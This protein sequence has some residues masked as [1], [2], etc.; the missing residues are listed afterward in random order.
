MVPRARL[1][2]EVKRQGFGSAFYELAYGCIH[3]RS[4]QAASHDEDDGPFARKTEMFG[5]NGR[6][7][8]V[9]LNRIQDLRSQRIA[10]FDDAFLGE[11][12]LQSRKARANQA[13]AFGEQAV[14][15]AGERV[16]FLYGCRDAHAGGLVEHRSA[17]KSADANNQLRSE[18]SQDAAGVPQRADELQR[19]DPIPQAAPIPVY[20]CDPKAFDRIPGGG[21]FFHFHAPF[22]PDK[23][24]VAMGMFALDLICDGEGRVDVAAGAAAGDDDPVQWALRISHGLRVVARCGSWRGGLSAW[25]SSNGPTVPGPLRSAKQRGSS[26]WRGT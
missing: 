7:E 15:D 4:A 19:E 8:C 24:D 5:C 12:P 20:S 26:R 14:G 23:E 11:P 6:G 9:V 17:G 10:G 22:C 16:L 21:N 2:D 25:Q 18:F 1:P 3:G 13:H